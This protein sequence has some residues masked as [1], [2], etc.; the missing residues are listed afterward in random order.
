MSIRIQFDIE[1]P[2]RQAFLDELAERVRS[3]G[4]VNKAALAREALVE[5]LA[6]RGH[7]VNDEGGERRG[8]YRGNADG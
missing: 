1:G 2:L 5:Y 8:G 4:D 7:S 6:M 3:G